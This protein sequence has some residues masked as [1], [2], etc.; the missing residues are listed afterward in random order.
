MKQEIEISMNIQ[1]NF[2]RQAEESSIRSRTLSLKT[3]SLAAVRLPEIFGS[4]DD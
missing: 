1:N 3:C 4:I 2:L